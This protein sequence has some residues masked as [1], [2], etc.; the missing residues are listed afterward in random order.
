MLNVT[1]R[2]DTITSYQKSWTTGEKKEWQ[3]PR[4]KGGY[5]NPMAGRAGN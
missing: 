2:A 4:K 1:K 3:Y 5:T